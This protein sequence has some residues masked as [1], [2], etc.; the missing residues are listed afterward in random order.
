MKNTTPLADRLVTLTP[1]L[2]KYAASHADGNTTADDL[3]QIACEEI[4]L[5]CSPTDNDTYML[6]LAD[7]RMRNAANRERVYSVRIDA[8]EFEADGEDDEE[9]IIRD[10]SGTPEEITTHREMSRRMQEVI[11]TL[12][13]EYVNLLAMLS[14]DLSHRE[15]ARRLGVSQPKISYHIRKIREI[16]QQAGLHPAFAMA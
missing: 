11:N 16:F 5:N 6:R 3:F 4:L 9:I 12:K 7:W 14:E 1:R 15:I 10:V 13:P 8:V 2:K